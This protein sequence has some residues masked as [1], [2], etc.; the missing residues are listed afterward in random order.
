M[1]L[2]CRF[3]AHCY[4]CTG[5]HAISPRS[6]GSFFFLALCLLVAYIWFITKYPDAMR[7]WV[8]TSSILISHFQTVGIIANLR[9]DWPPSVVVVTSVINF[10]MLDVSLYRPECLLLHT[11]ASPF[12]IF[13]IAACGIVLVL[14]VGMS[15]FTVVV[16]TCGK[17]CVSKR[18]RDAIVDSVE[19]A[20]SIVFSLQ[21]TTTWTVIMSLLNTINTD[22]TFGPIGGLCAGLARVGQHGPGWV[23]MGQDGPGLVR[24]GSSHNRVVS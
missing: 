21:L 2:S 11:S 6:Q 16:K 13:T 10:N 1:H 19:F 12:F 20:Q 18:T 7:R 9:I 3:C 17:L 23:R 24:I 5:L 14:M 15:S 22:E 8:S 4:T